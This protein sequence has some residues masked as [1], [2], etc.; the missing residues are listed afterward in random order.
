MK[1]PFTPSMLYTSIAL[2]YQNMELIADLVMPRTQVLSREFAY[3]LYTKSEMFTIPDTKVGRKGVPNE[4][5]FTA[6]ESTAAALDYGLQFVV[7]Q[8]DIDAAAGKPALDPVG[9]HTTGIT[10]L[11]MLD[12]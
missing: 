2:A 12:R 11:L 8:D 6:T 1:Y 3:D 9:R 5:E 7:P 10:E 4:V